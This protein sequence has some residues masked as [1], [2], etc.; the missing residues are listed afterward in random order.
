M[1][2]SFP[3]WYE[4]GADDMEFVVKCLLEKYLDGVS[5]DVDGVQ[6]T[7]EVK[8]W[9]GEGWRNKLP[10]ICIARVPG[11]IDEDARFD[12]GVVQVWVICESRADSWELATF[13]NEVLRAHDRRG[14]MVDVGTYR[15]DVRH[16]KRTAGPELTMDEDALNERVIP[17]A[18]E[19]RMKRRVSLPNYDDIL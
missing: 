4:G 5:V 12:T 7:P 10:L 16:I 11:G 1:S 13:V 6:R 9:L 19:I 2:F 17:M 3:D 15:A 14:A 18:Y 8:A